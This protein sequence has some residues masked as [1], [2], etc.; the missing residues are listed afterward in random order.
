[1]NI[2]KARFLVYMTRKERITYEEAWELFKK[3]SAKHNF[4]LRPIAEDIT[5]TYKVSV[6]KDTVGTLLSYVS[7]EERKALKEAQLEEARRIKLPERIKKGMWVDGIIGIPKEINDFLKRAPR[8]QRLIYYHAIRR[9]FMGLDYTWKDMDK[10]KKPESGIAEALTEWLDEEFKTQGLAFEEKHKQ[11]GTR[12]ALREFFKSLGWSQGDIDA[13]LPQVPK[14]PPLKERVLNPETLFLYP[15]EFE[16]W[17]DCID[18]VSSEIKKQVFRKGK[19]YISTIKITATI[20]KSFK[21][22][23]QFAFETG[24]RTGQ[25]LGTLADGTIVGKGILGIRLQNIHWEQPA[26]GLAKVDLYDKK[27]LIWHKYPSPLWYQLTQDFIAEY[28]KEIDVRIIELKKK[29]QL[30]NDEEEELK[31]LEAWKNGYGILYEPLKISLLSDLYRATNEICWEKHKL[32]K[33]FDIDEE[34]V[35]KGEDIGTH[36]TARALRKT[37]ATLSQI[38]GMDALVACELG[39]WLDVSTFK[40]YYAVIPPALMTT[41]SIKYHETQCN[42]P[43]ET[44]E[45]VKA[46]TSKTLGIDWSK[47]EAGYEERMKEIAGYVRPTVEES[48]EETE[49]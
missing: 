5:K 46:E 47:F 8:R 23:M 35:R 49:E 13:K 28:T 7:D 34:A 2:P 40:R 22:F 21:S 4:T 27:D 16:L 26:K 17:R 36:I 29:T 18:E 30:T 41:W 32:L 37:F 39:G 3:I 25:Q 14:Y 43:K 24:T 20:R 9:A 19:P 33:G 15:H 1:M 6:G 31:R 12:S 44:L 38:M 48:P 42:I 45:K 11:Y 10:W